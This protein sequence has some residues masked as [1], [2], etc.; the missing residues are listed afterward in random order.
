MIIFIAILKFPSNCN[1]SKEL[2][3]NELCLRSK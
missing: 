2:I 1:C 3:A